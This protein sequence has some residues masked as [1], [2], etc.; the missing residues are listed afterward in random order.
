ME[1]R[2][3]IQVKPGQVIMCDGPA[4]EWVEDP[5]ITAKDVVAQYLEEL[6]VNH[7]GAMVARIGSYTALRKEQ[8]IERLLS[9]DPRDS[10][11]IA[12]SQITVALMQAVLKI[13]ED[14]EKSLEFSEVPQKK[15]D[16]CGDIA[17]TLKIL[18]QADSIP[19]SDPPSEELIQEVESSRPGYIIERPTNAPQNP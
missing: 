14:G 10:V 13:I 5:N 11:E 2:D 12:K 6:V 1:S 7:D 17:T 3:T 8:A 4:P 19:K 16:L 9:D 15:P 18:D